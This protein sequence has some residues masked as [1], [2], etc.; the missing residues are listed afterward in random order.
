MAGRYNRVTR[1]LGESIRGGGWDWIGEKSEGIGA[2]SSGLEAS[3]LEIFVILSLSIVSS[4][5]GVVSK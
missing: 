1:V 5:L 2:L 4:S 3:V